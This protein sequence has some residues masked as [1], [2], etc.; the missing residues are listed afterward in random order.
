VF[1]STDSTSTVTI[2]VTK[3]SDG[4]FYITGVQKS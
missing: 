3:E 1:K 4:H 2:K